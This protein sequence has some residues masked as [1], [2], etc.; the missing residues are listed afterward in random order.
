MSNCGPMA[1]WSVLI[2]QAHDIT[3]SHT[4]VPGMDCYLWH[5]AEM[6]V[7]LARHN[8]GEIWP[9][10]HLGNTVGLILTVGEQMN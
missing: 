10:C 6:A 2:P 4:E 5:H 1:A 7:P 8:T 3:K 9:T